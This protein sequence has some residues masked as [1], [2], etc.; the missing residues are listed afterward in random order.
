MKKIFLASLAF[1][2]LC[3]PVLADSPV[4]STTFSEAYQDLPLIVEAQTGHQL[5]PAMAAFLS[6][7]TQPL[8]QRLALVNALG[9]KFEGQNNAAL[10]L[11]HLQI[12][13]QQAGARP[14]QLA[15]SA[16]E[17]LF[18]GYLMVLDN[19]FEPR[20]GVQWV[21]RGARQ[22]WQSQSAQ[23]VL[24][25]V[26]AQDYINRSKLWCQIWLQTERALT[27][28]RLKA[29]LRPQARKLIVEY[30]ELY[31]PYCRSENP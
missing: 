13:K 15:L 16:E 21:R 7:N 10:W 6:D 25:I 24:A 20:P 30:L 29:D 12:Q 28:T 3:L 27:D 22:L 14:E 1:L 5:T 4:T 11:K 2:G 19:Y 31:Q 18:L 23:L 9:W 26:E 8:D 17:Q